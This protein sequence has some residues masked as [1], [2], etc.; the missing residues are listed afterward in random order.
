MEECAIF[1][2]VLAMIELYWTNWNAN[3]RILWWLLRHLWTCLVFSGRVIWFPS[4]LDSWLDVLSTAAEDFSGYTCMTLLACLF[5]RQII[6]FSLFPTLG[7]RSEQQISSQ[8]HHT[9][10]GTISVNMNRQVFYNSPL[11][12]I[13]SCP[14]GT[15]MNLSLPL[16]NTFCTISSKSLPTQW[17]I[18]SHPNPLFPSILFLQV[19]HLQ[20]SQ[21]ACAASHRLKQRAINLLMRTIW[22]TA[23]E[24]SFRNTRNREPL[25]AHLVR[26][27]SFHPLQVS[28]MLIFFF[29]TRSRHLEYVPRTERR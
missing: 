8:A 15:Q 23:R 1:G 18:L 13:P 26:R 16:L 11:P 3:G 6:N 5:S 4:L 25:H 22:T 7:N 17:N 9:L 19:L 12:E 27:K 10:S 28:L 20:R 24:A 21:E 2:T 14:P 29:L